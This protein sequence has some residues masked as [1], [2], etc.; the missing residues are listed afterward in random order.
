MIILVILLITTYLFNKQKY[1]QIVNKIK[2]FFT[3][4][5]FAGFCYTQSHFGKVKRNITAGNITDTC[6]IDYISTNKEKIKNKNV[7]SSSTSIEDQTD[8]INVNHY[9][10]FV[11]KKSV[12]SINSSS[13]NSNSIGSNSTD[14]NLNNSLYDTLNKSKIEY[15]IVN[16]DVNK[17]IKIKFNS[18]D[19]LAY[20]DN[21]FSYPTIRDYNFFNDKC[22]KYVG[23]NSKLKKLSSYNCPLNKVKI[24]C[25]I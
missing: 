2:S 7:K 25:Q 3:K 8:I 13:I 20:I 12:N 19:N 16:D 24:G 22:I 6:I 5:N 21:C 18:Y 17:N 4:E 1:Y 9:P 10:N 11:N 14:I 15:N 23:Q